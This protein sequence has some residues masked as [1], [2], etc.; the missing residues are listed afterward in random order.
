MDRPAN[1]ENLV[2][3]KPRL[4]PYPK[5]GCAS[6]MRRRHR[7]NYGDLCGFGC[8]QGSNASTRTLCTMDRRANFE[9]LVLITRLGKFQRSHFFP[10]G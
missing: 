7:I 1:F 2:P 6:M 3:F 10:K 8:P 5:I 9:N 4:V